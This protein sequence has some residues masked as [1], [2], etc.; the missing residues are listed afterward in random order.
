MKK[1]TSSEI[2]QTWLD[3]FKSKNHHIEPGASLVP[4]NDPTLLWINAG[5]A[6]LKKYFDGSEIPPS[7]RIS[8]VQ[9][10]IRTNDIENVGDATHLTFFEMLGNFSIGDYFRKEVIPWAVEMLFDDKWFAFPKEKI[11]ITYHPDDLETK[12]CWMDAGIEESHLITKEDNFWEIGE[13]PCGPDTEVHF[14]RGEKYDP[15]HIGVRLLEEDLPNSRF[16]EIWN[17]VFSQFNSEPGK[18][19][20]E[21]K[22]LPHKNIDTG[23]GLERFVV[24]IQGTDT[25]YETDLFWP[26][27]EQTEKISGKKYSDNMRAFRVIADH[28]RT[29][30]FAL[31]DGAMFSNEGRGYVLRRLLR[32][33]TR[34]GKVLG[35]NK[36]FL[37]SLVDVV[38][39]IMKSFYP[40]LEGKKDF[41]KKVIEA[42]E[43]KFLKTLENGEDILMKMISK[44]KGLS[45]EDMFLLYDTYG[46]PK[47]LTLELCEE[48]NI[49]PDVDRFNELMKEQ[50]DRARAARKD[51]QSMNKQSAD[52]MAFDTPSTFTYGSEEVEAKVIGLFK[53]GKKVDV[54]SESGEV[55]LDTTN[56]YAESGGQI[57][58]TGTIKNDNFEARVVSVNKAPNKQHLH[59]IEVLFGEL[60]VGDKVHAEIDTKRR[61]LITRNHSSVHLLQQALT[62]V[63]GDHI[64]QH[65]SYVSDQYSHFDFSHFKKMSD[66]EIAEVERKVNGWISDAI[67]EE[68]KVL[69]I[70]EAKK[71][72]AKALF[73]DKYGDTVRVVMFGDVSKEFCGGTH[74]K[75]TS[76]IGIFVIESEESV[77]S[78]VRRITARTSIGAYNL[79]KKRENLLNMAKESLGASSYFEVNDRLNA[80]KNE[81]DLLKKN[82]EALSNKLSALEA[83]KLLNE[84]K[85]ENDI[86]K[87]IVYLPGASRDTIFGLLD[88]IKG[89]YPDHVFLFIGEVNLPIVV[90]VSGKA[91]EKYNAG[92]LVKKVAGILGGSGGGRPDMASGAG[93]DPSKVKEALGAINE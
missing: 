7:R 71:L 86:A 77:A 19:R 75:N 50:R 59:R 22:E 31:A 55:M 73:N 56:F 43:V 47:E 66:E 76:D 81:K 92:L 46:F 25:V 70:D 48:Q 61:L 80:L 4:I 45:G 63:L 54:I 40:Y 58:D 6:A 42:E 34:F 72:G 41:V 93:K 82:N 78:G 2:R 32:R 39:D 38:V 62:E 68:T 20:S 10:S 18:K 8:N 33:A 1:M 29:C 87:L 24:V 30:T 65:G 85:V 17:I 9:K 57:S 90:S 13:G 3:F 53:D 35:I 60:K 52:L 28:M 36:P 16:V 21:Y 37:Y 44:N 49:K 5:V 11:Y 64:A 74:V 27:I 12:K 69:P 91:K 14:D 79:L 83:N 84:I 26:I 23:A 89:R 88:S 15:E 51:E 67:E